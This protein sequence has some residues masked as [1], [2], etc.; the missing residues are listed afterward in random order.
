MGLG[1]IL[2]GV[3][4]FVGG[5]IGNSEASGEQEKARKAFEDALA[6]WQ[7]LNPE[8]GASAVGSLDPAARNAQ[9]DA[10]AHMQQVYQQGGLTTQD[11]VAQEQAMLAAAQQE[12]A[13]RGAIQQQMAA[14]GQAGGGAELA[15]MLS[16]QQGSAMASHM[17]GQQ[18]AASAQQR[19]L[20]A[21]MESGQMGGMVRGQDLQKA[22]AQDLMSRFNAAQ[23]TTKVGGIAG[24]QTNL[25]G[26]YG[27]DA[28]RVR[29]Q[30]TGMGQGLGTALGGAGD[31]L[32]SQGL[33][34]S[35]MQS[36]ALGS[37]KKPQQG[38]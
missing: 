21:M 23:R 32:A 19:A 12:R 35:G 3:G 31:A 13:Q 9:M 34:G 2:G 33:L 29:N 15:G 28:Q 18:A 24:A 38:G 1:D 6:A 30:Y 37:S 22:Q 8:A 7:Q 20:E 17:A 26:Y 14:R 16:G 25:G 4:G 11:R 5:L 10:L 36:W 27:G